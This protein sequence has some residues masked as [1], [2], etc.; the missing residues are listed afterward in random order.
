MSMLKFLIA[1][2]LAAGLAAP[3]AQADGTAPRTAPEKRPAPIMKRSPTDETRTMPRARQG[4]T[5][6]SK[7]FTAPRARASAR[8]AGH[9]DGEDLTYSYLPTHPSLLAPGS[10]PAATTIGTETRYYYDAH[11]SPDF[12]GAPCPTRSNTSLGELFA[13]TWR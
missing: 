6:L 3:A 1:F 4:E 7:I 10:G 2:A 9:S 5:R 11:V 13:C 12:D 8:I